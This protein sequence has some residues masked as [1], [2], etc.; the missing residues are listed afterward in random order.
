MRRS[1]DQIAKDL[2][3]VTDALL[4]L[5]D[6]DFARRFEIL[7]ERDA[8]RAE[9]AE[10]EADFDEQRPTPDIVDELREVRRRRSAL[11]SDQASRVMASGPGGTGGAAGAVSGEMAKLSIRARAAS[12][13]GRLTQRVGQLESLL[14]ERGVD[15]EEALGTH[16]AA[17]D[18]GTDPSP[19]TP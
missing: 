2:A 7:T 12:D 8:L 15:V 9:A 18:P 10:L 6:D 4:E 11:V 5:S 17:P 14:A 19:V 16:H 1:A 3:R 13:L